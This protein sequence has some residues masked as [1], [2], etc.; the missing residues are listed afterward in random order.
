[1]AVEPPGRTAQ[2]SDRGVMVDHQRPQ[3]LSPYEN[4]TRTIAES[5]PL[6]TTRRAAVERCGYVARDGWRYGTAAPFCDAPALAGASYCARHHA[7][8]T[9]QPGS[10]AAETAVRA[11]DR[12]ADVV[13][14]PPPELAYLD[15]AAVPELEA[16]AERA[17]I[18]ACLD[19]PPEGGAAVE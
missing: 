10:A 16:A 13:P 8:C 14:T 18:A 1:V 11:L 17:D 6:V 4:I 9:I 5:P 7:L 15:V 19:L 12:I 2:P 3:P